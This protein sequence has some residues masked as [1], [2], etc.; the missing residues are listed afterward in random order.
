[1]AR[2]DGAPYRVECRLA[3]ADGTYRRHRLD[4][5]PAGDGGPATR[6]IVTGTDLP[7]ETART[8][9]RS[10]V[11]DDLPDGLYTVDGDGRLT[12]LNRAA[13][14]MLGWTEQDLLGASVHD[15]VH[16]S[17]RHDERTGTPVRADGCRLLPGFAKPQQFV[18]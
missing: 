14:Q 7:H 11:I 18:F 10:A 4:F 16:A 6:W 3:A 17:A 5:A 8:P 1:M 2:R 13:S 15:V 12:A 9:V